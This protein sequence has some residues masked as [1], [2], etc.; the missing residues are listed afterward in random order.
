MRNRL[1][2]E[3]RMTERESI[4]YGMNYDYLTGHPRGN[5][6]YSYEKIIE[7]IDKSGIKLLTTAHHKEVALAIKEGKIIPKR[8]LEE[9]KRF[10]CGTWLKQQQKLKEQEVVNE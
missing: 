9:H 8:V 10:L 1:K 2:C 7:V 5:D 6:I 4:V 3:W